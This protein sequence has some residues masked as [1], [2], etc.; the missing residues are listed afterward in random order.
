M[1][2]ILGLSI[3]TAARIA[4]GIILMMYNGQFSDYVMDRDLL[5]CSS[6]HLFGDLLHFII[7]AY[8]IYKYSIVAS[9]HSLEG[10][11]RGMT[12]LDELKG[13]Y[14]SN[15]RG[16][17]M[18]DYSDEYDSRSD[19]QNWYGDSRNMKAMMERFN[20]GR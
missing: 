14:Q 15:L 18:G 2:Q 9:N 3:W 10:R 17:A 5:I 4:Y 13:Q 6:V 11:Q 20:N 19:S 12:L 8:V 1:I 16:E 7:I